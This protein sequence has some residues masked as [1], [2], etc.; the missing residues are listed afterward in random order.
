MNTTRTTIDEKTFA[1]GI[2]T[3][4]A[5]I[6]LAAL[7]LITMQP[8]YAIGQLDRGG[9][10]IMLTQQ[11]SNS[12]EGVIIIDAASR[13]MTLYAFNGANRQLQLLHQNIPLDQMPGARRNE[14]GVP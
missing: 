12:Q 9:D 13:Q 5:C 3:V 11:L 2:L 14:P 10:Y 7:L 1:I 4:T 6:L 8:A